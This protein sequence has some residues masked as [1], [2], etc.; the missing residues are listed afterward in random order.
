M[1]GENESI[2]S[3]SFR[4]RLRFVHLYMIK[5]DRARIARPDGQLLVYASMRS[6]SPPMMTTTIPRG[7]S[8]FE[9]SRILAFLVVFS[10]SEVDKAFDVVSTVDEAGMVV[11]MVRGSCLLSAPSIVLAYKHIAICR[12]QDDLR[13][14]GGS[15]HSRAAFPDTSRHTRRGGPSNYTGDCTTSN[16]AT[17]TRNDV[18]YDPTQKRKTSFSRGRLVYP[19]YRCWYRYSRKDSS[20]PII[21]QAIHTKK[22]D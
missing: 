7:K 6:S 4:C 1:S 16:Q 15:R 12:A 22:V 8:L 3:P 13:G 17:S 20:F 10:G 9:G 21:C 11:K 18:P 14:W 2:R 19:C 5:A